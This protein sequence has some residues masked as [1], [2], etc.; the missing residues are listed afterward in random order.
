MERS[1]KPRLALKYVPKR[2]VG[3]HNSWW[4]NW[5]WQDVGNQKVGRDV[6]LMRWLQTQ[7]CKSKGGRPG[8]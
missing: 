2:P 6:S 3:T 5:A 7:L 4:S 1:G 8:D